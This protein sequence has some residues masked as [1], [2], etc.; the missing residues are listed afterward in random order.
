M[1]IWRIAPLNNLP[2]DKD[3]FDYDCAHGFVVK[4]ETEADARALAQANGGDEVGRYLP[5][6]ERH[7][8]PQV[9]IDPSYTECIEVTTEGEQEIILTDFVNG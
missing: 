5:E 3:V 8:A 2:K 6:G 1:K 7:T 9:W 4:A